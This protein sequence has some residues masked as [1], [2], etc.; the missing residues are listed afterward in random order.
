MPEIYTKDGPVWR[1]FEMF[2]PQTAPLPPPEA[3]WKRLPV[4][5]HIRWLAAAWRIERHYNAWAS[6]GRLPSYRSYDERC[7][8]AIKDGRI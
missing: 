5:R 7:L 1:E 2:D 3:A 8:A 4:I 6:L